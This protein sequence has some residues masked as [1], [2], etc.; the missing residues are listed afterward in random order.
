MYS[1]E[2]LISITQG[3][4]NRFRENRINVNY[5]SELHDA[6]ISEE[7]YIHGNSMKP[8]YP[9]VS[10]SGG[11]ER[12]R[13]VD[14]WMHGWNLTIDLYRALSRCNYFETMYDGE[15]RGYEIPFGIDKATE[16]SEPASDDIISLYTSLP[17]RF[18]EWQPERPLLSILF[19]D[20]YQDIQAVHILLTLQ[21]V[22]M[23]LV[24]KSSHLKSAEEKIA[25]LRDLLNT[26]NQIPFYYLTIVCTAN[27]YHVTG[28]CNIAQ[29]V[30]QGRSNKQHFQQ[31]SVTQAV[32]VANIL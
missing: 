17:Q 4:R 30:L 5:P 19:T 15:P 6:L 23:T 26:L 12:I 1:L 31:I 2:S 3:R 29:S 7:G 14:H 20:D 8:D 24:N 28:L 9:K 18:K 16:L 13:Q 27:M 10:S 21:L 25:F 11:Y 22:R 32:Q